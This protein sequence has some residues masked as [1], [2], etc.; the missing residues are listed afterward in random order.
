MA[1]PVTIRGETIGV[2]HVQDHE[3][4]R[5]WSQD[6]KAMVNTIA[7]QVAAALENARLFENVVRRA[8]REKKALE[9]TAR[10][11]SSNNPGEMM[12]IAVSELQQA[13]GATR[14]QI[15]IR[16]SEQDIEEYSP[17]KNGSNPE[18]GSNL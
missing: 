17:R 4:G 12:Q 16:R 1:I 18:K 2:I 9:I 13:L 15:Y 11:R 14:T 10:I 3:Q 8:E 6:E 7:S 5:T